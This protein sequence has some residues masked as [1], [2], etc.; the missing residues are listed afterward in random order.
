MRVRLAL[1]AF[2]LSAVAT[3]IYFAQASRAEEAS[4]PRKRSTTDTAVTEDLLAT[5]RIGLREA[6]LGLLA[7]ERNLE[8]VT[9]VPFNVPMMGCASGAIG[10]EGFWIHVYVTPGGHDMMTTGKGVYPPGT[11]ILK[12]KFLDAVGKKTELFTGMLKREKGYAPQVGDW[13]FFVLNAQATR[14]TS[15]KN[16]LISCATCH[17]SFR[18]T[19]FVSRSYLTEKKPPEWPLIRDLRH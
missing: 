14:V 9:A 10:H 16:E 19:D 5:I 11:L 3:V 12:Q 2:A 8:R 13:E 18:D 17:E 1:T 7:R 15:M 6:G 4:Q